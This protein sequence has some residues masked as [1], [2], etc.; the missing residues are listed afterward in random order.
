[1]QAAR[2]LLS[3]CWRIYHFGWHGGALGV[4]QP[5]LGDLRLIVYNFQEGVNLIF[6]SLYEMFVGHKQLGLQGQ[7]DLNA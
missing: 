3:A 7:Q 6:F 4:T 2:P 5:R 1:M